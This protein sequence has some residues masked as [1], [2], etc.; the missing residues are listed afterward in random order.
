MSLTQSATARIFNFSAG[1][2]VLPVSVL[3]RVQDEL[4]ALPGRGISVLEISHRSATFDQIAESAESDLRRLAGIPD[5]YRVLFL[6]GGASMQFAMVPMNLLPTGATAD[7]IVT[8]SWSQKALR[9][10]QRIGMARVAGSTEPDS[11][12]RIPR[13]DELDRVRPCD[14]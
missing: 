13:Q 3:E 2:A 7:Y 12:S 4:L 11:F 14:V 10:A 9:V 8:G 5:D 6:Q 1:P